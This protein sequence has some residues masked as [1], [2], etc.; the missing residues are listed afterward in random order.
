V[1]A[2]N[3][4]VRGATPHVARHWRGHHK[5]EADLVIDPSVDRMFIIVKLEPDTDLNDGPG[6][7]GSLMAASALHM[8]RLE[9]MNPDPTEQ[10]YL[11]FPLTAV[12]AAAARF[13]RFAYPRRW[14]PVGH[15]SLPYEHRRWRWLHIEMDRRQAAQLSVWLDSEMEQ[16]R[17]LA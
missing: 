7:V 4:H 1:S 2:L 13:A 14:Q 12:S 3:L 10:L 5:L 15:E 17:L 6:A 11:T 8:L 9:L 16:G